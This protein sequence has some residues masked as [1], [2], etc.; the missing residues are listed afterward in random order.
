MVEKTSEH[1]KWL[2]NNNDKFLI[3]TDIKDALRTAMVAHFNQQTHARPRIKPSL[4]L[5][6]TLAVVEETFS[7]DVKTPNVYCL[8]IK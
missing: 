2:Y 6:N 7:N 5:G 1:I 8:S 4:R 3:E